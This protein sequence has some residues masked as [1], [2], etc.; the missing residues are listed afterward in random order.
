MFV[1]FVAFVALADRCA[2][3]M[4]LATGRLH[5]TDYFA[6]SNIVAE[7]NADDDFG[8]GVAML[9]PDEIASDGSV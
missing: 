6:V 9:L 5:V 3:F 2:A 7:S 8:S 4:K 1:V